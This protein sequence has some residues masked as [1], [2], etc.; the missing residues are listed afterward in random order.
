MKRK[1]FAGIFIFSCLLQPIYSSAISK[2]MPVMNTITDSLATNAVLLRLTEIMAVDKSTLNRTEKKALRKE[3]RSL[4]KQANG[5]NKGIYL[6]V[7]AIIIIILLLIL[8]L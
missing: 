1:L 8:I 2:P 7:G 5:N 4:K 3:L 6:S